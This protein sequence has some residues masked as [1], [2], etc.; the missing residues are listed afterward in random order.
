MSSAKK[1][2][3][4]GSDVVAKYLNGFNCR[5]SLFPNEDHSIVTCTLSNTVSQVMQLLIANRVKYLNSILNLSHDV[6]FFFVIHFEFEISHQIFH[7]DEN[8]Q[9]KWK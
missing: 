3:L 1:Q 4:D 6:K 7:F 9:N 8:E 2:K 5:S